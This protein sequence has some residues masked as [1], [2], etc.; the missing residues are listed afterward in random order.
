MKNTKIHMDTLLDNDLA[1]YILDNFGAC[2]RGSDCSKGVDSQGHPNGCRGAGWR[3][4]NCPHW[5]PIDE[6]SWRE[7]KSIYVRATSSSVAAPKWSK[8]GR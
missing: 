4:R 2:A 5:R 8:E 7:L 1:D 3:G 6:A